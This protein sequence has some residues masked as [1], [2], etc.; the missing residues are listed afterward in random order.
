VEVTSRHI[1]E[2]LAFFEEQLREQWDADLVWRGLQQ[3]EVVSIALLQSQDKPQVIF[4]SMNSTGKDLSSADLIRNFV[5]MSYPIEEQDEVYRVYWQPIERTLG[6]QVYDG[7]FDDFIR[8]Y[9]TV[10]QP[11]SLGN[12]G[13]AYQAFKRYVIAREYRREDRMRILVLRL[14]RFA[15]YY[16]AATTGAIDDLELRE[17]LSRIERLMQPAVNPLLLALFDCFEHASLDREG[18]L[19]ALGMLESYL[20]RRLICACDQ[21]T[22]P[23]LVASLIA[24]IQAAA[25]ESA[26]VGQTL[27]VA[28]LNEAVGATRF[29]G[30][31]EFSQALAALAEHRR[32][33]AE[34][35]EHDAVDAGFD[36]LLLAQDD[37]RLA[38]GDDFV[39]AAIALW[40]RPEVD[41]ETLAVYRSS[42]QARALAES[43]GTDATI[44]IGW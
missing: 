39:S 44:T 18:F 13:D 38:A 34:S 23:K 31:A 7:V 1:R 30:D 2:N 37:E 36:P 42:E 28:L 8:C 27:E 14:S 12:D 6:A 15:G 29:P 11:L 21:T 35:D 26:P 16:V 22:L 3:L 32:V 41:E 25:A 4:E 24:R 5:L 19:G 17:A 43:E 33:L 20:F 10:S 9:L 40:S